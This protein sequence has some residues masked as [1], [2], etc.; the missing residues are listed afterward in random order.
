MWTK[1]N[2]TLW[3]QIR[4]IIED[5][6]R[7]S[8]NS[9]I[10]SVLVLFITS[11]ASSLFLV[12]H[13]LGGTAKLG[14]SKD[15]SAVK[16]LIP[17]ILFDNMVFVS[18]ILVVV[19][20]GAKINGIE[21]TIISTCASICKRHAHDARWILIPLHNGSNAKVIVHAVVGRCPIRAHRH[22]AER[23]AVSVCGDQAGH[24]RPVGQVLS[25]HFLSLVAAQ[26]H[27]TDCVLCTVC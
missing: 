19:F 7:S 25:F 3:L 5:F 6:D 24:R 16:A 11:G 8:I 23:I 9:S 17:L 27:N 13:F 2:L 12:M 26:H 4:T 15:S 20:Y 18:F 10:R 22:A 21:S 1:D 14:I